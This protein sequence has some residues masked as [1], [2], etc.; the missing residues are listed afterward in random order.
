MATKATKAL[1][2]EWQPELDLVDGRENAM[3]LD[4]VATTHPVVQH[5]ETVDQMSQ[6]FDAITYQ[7]GEAVITMLED[8]V[9]SD[10]WRRGV[11]AY[12]RAH[13]LSNTQSDDLWRAV[14]GAAGK[15]VT[16]IAHD[17]TLQPGIPLIRVESAACRG[18]RTLLVLRQSEFSRDRPEKAPLAWR[19]PVIAAGLSGPPARMLVEGGGGTIEVAGC[20]PVVVNSGQTGYY[21]TLYAPAML[22]ALA[23]AYPRLKPIDQIGLL[24]DWWGLGLA[25]YQPASAALD[26]VQAMPADA[27]P[28]LVGRAARILGQVH[29]LFDGDERHQAMAARYVEARLEPVLA[30]IGWNARPDE[31]APVAILRTDLIRALG[32]VGDPRIV[33]EANRLYDSHDRLATQGALRTTILAVVARN[34]DAARWER[35]RAEAKAEKN[36]LVRAQLYRLLAA[37]HD[38]A[39]ARRALDMALTAEPGATTGSAMIAAVSGDHPDLAFDFAIANRERVEALV[40]ASSRS[41]F[42]PGL[43]GGASDPAMIAKLE[44]YA[45]RY[46][47]PQSRRPADIAIGAIR[48]RV[49]VRRDRLPDIARWLDTHTA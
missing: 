20:G 5:I 45:T 39:L 16:A 15:P 35:L 23:G 25:G 48:D 41:R 8:Y 44:D 27:S 29:G 36:P 28:R 37:A 13:R 38:P 34:V 3:R 33:A 7:K 40:D 19:V 2:P 49:K 4:S 6:A 12:I 46:M 31:A 30:R 43:G 18:G 32:G 17:F 21:R 11:Q 42:I 1:H 47:T 22:T 14:E 10:A 24:A 9:G 26:L